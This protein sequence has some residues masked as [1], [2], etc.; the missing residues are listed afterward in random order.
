MLPD[1]TLPQDEAPDLVNPLM[2]EFIQRHS[3]EGADAAAA[4]PDEGGD[5]AAWRHTS[6]GAAAE[7]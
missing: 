1:A 6:E 2:L 3:S 7:A 4:P 5:A